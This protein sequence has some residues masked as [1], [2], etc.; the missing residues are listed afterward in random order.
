MKP[1]FLVSR[2]QDVDYPQINS[3]TSATGTMATA[4]VISASPTLVLDPRIDK[5]SSAP[6]KTGPQD[7]HTV[8]HYYKPNEDGSPPHPTYVDRP[9]TYERPFEVH[10]VT[11]QDV[12]GR[13]LEYTLDRSGFQLHSHTTNEKDFIDDE[14]IKSGYYTETEKLLKDVY[15]TEDLRSTVTALTGPGLAQLAFSSSTT[16]SDA[17]HRVKSR[18]AATCADQCNVFI[19][20]TV[21]GTKTLQT[22]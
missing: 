21:Q 18:L 16:L 4:A 11:V 14:Q 8:L 3:V 10:P 13:E 6:T 22:D 15:V 12:R 20:E 17:S 7:V 1:R 19:C 9:E 5:S 2:H